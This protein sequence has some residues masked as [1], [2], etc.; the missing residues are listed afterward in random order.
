M[1]DDFDENSK[2]RGFNDHDFPI[3]AKYHGPYE[4]DM[5]EGKVSYTI[6][7]PS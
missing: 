5:K 7:H 2:I 6:N 3:P 1:K 4:I